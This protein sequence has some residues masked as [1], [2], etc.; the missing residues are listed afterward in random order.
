[1][2]G[3]LYNFKF[4]TLS[5][6]FLAV[7]VFNVFVIQNGPIGPFIL[8]AWLYLISPPLGRAALPR[9][10]RINQWAAGLFLGLSAVAVV[11][12]LF[13]YL[14][15][16]TAPAAIT[17]VLLSLPLVWIVEQRAGK[18]AV[19]AKS[20]HNPLAETNSRLKIVKL[21]AALVL[22]AL[23][24]TM[25]LIAGSATTAAVRSPWEIITP[26]VFIVFGL[27]ALLLV[28]LLIRGRERA[29]SLLLIMAALFV[30]LSVALL[31]FPLGYGFDSFIHQATEKHIAE[32]ASITPKPF[33][34]LGQY[35]LVLFF[36]HAFLIPVEWADKL[37]L[38][39]LTALLLPFMWILAAAHLLKEKQAAIRSLAVL[40]LIPLSSFIVTTPQGLGNLWF[41][42]LLLLAAPRLCDPP[43]LTK[44]RSGGR[45]PIWPMVLGVAAALLFHPIAG[46]PAILFLVLLAADPNDPKQKNPTLARIF[47]WIIFV[48]GCFA[49][50][51]T[52]VMNNLRSGQS[53][54]F[55]FSALTST[56][57][58]HN[59][60]LDLFFENRF[61]PILDFVYLFGWNQIILLIIGAIIG[62]VWSRRT[63]LKPT[64]VYLA[65][66]MV[67]FI[68]FLVI[69]SA[70]DF[71]FL[72]DYE[73]S[74]Y[75][76]RLI[77][78][79]V[80]C[81]VP[82]LI[83]FIGRWLSVLRKKTFV[84]Q[85]AAVVLLAALITSAFYLN[86]PRQDAY[87]TSRGFNVSQADITTV[88]EVNS[89]AAGA[90]YVVLA[91][92]SASAAAL[93]E[94]GFVRYY[95]DQFYYPIPTGGTLYQF[96][97]KMNEEPS[98]T[99]A[100]TVMNLLGVNRVYYLVSDYWWQAER[101]RETAKTNADDWWSVEDGMV[102]IFE[103]EK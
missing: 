20:G 75:A 74:N 79:A 23:T 45:L 88:R 59:L 1:M 93:R 94:F 62:M 101:I 36:H 13:Y 27:G 82:F 51:L 84:L 28:S 103:Y 9:E 19:A 76:D 85:A 11:G 102:M 17:I 12:S 3:L 67:L 39:I 55:N 64:R 18:K 2:K 86:Y 97:L 60:R 48:F 40:F 41:L 15:V 10:G 68:N 5:A 77:P 29:L 57:L 70:V 99:T 30:F 72:I 66:A 95:D 83:I 90:D 22:I 53:P 71:S 6:I 46:I 54:G 7:F 91:N 34:Y 26:T 92:Q 78:L 32:F 4:T 16:F 33:Y 24:E 61:S 35:S 65:M 31:V 80:F 8:T 69:R 47:S 56:G 49:L 42:L 14:A 100:L 44:E 58:I 89:K 87:E 38:P 98:K 63:I 50:P 81:L 43:L 96:F 37:L 25:I 52:F 21:T 73:R